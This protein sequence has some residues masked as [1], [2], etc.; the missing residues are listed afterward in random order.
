MVEP[1][2]PVLSVWAETGQYL[3]LADAT[4]IGYAMSVALFEDRPDVVL[5]LWDLDAW[6]PLVIL[7][8]TPVGVLLE[9]AEATLFAARRARRGEAVRGWATAAA[10]AGELLRRRGVPRG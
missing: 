1:P 10:R 8:T 5:R 4:S 9:W 7:S 6:E 3:V 2:D